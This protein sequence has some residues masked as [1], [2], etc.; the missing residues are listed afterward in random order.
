MSCAYKFYAK[1]YDEA[2][3][4]PSNTPKT[5]AE[6]IAYFASHGITLCIQKNLSSILIFDLLNQH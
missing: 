3:C 6:L 1:R 4:P 2:A 5:V